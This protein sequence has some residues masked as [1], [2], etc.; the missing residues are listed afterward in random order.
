M[1]KKNP[2][3]LQS[4]IDAYSFIEFSS[5]KT[6]IN[7]SRTVELMRLVYEKLYSQ[8][9][10]SEPKFFVLLLLSQEEDGIPLIEIGKMML[11]TRANITTLMDRMERDGLVEKRKN[12]DDKRST[13]AHL[14]DEGRRI[15]DMIKG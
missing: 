9:K 2:S 10:I 1:S 7:L 3:E 12:K 5:G 13:K 4:Y 15:F 14:T 8:Y 11:V 6:I